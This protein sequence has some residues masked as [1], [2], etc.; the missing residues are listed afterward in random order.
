EK[1]KKRASILEEHFLSCLLHLR[2]LWSM[3]AE[4]KSRSL[5][6]SFLHGARQKGHNTDRQAIHLYIYT[7]I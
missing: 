6:P 2:L 3:N 1:K 4:K 7:C 5:H